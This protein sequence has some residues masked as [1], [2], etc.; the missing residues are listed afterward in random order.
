ML[1]QQYV[2]SSARLSAEHQAGMELLQRSTDSSMRTANNSM[3]AWTTVASDWRDY[4]ADRQTVSGANGTY[5]TSN[6]YSNVWSSPVGPALSDGL[7]L[8]HLTTPSIPTPQLTISGPRAPRSTATDSLTSPNDLDR[9][10]S[11][12]RRAGV[13]A[14]QRST[15]KHSVMKPGLL[16]AFVLSSLLALAF[17]RGMP[18]PQ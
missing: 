10:L 15:Y 2:A 1:H 11:N 17:P 13:L 16:T 5:K 6:Q 9:P 12:R 4:A 7:P 3:N 14:I 18:R 8:A